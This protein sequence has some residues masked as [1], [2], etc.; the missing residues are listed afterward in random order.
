MPKA[1]SPSSV[2]REASSE[3]HGLKPTWDVQNPPA[4]SRRLI[5]PACSALEVRKI[6]VQSITF[7][8]IARPKMR[9]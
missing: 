8:L 9:A 4:R 6:R 5:I 1:I 2:R 7:T 3:W